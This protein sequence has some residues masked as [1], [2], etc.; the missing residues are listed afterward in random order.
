MVT[1]KKRR[2][3]ARSCLESSVWRG[4]DQNESEWKVV[5]RVVVKCRIDELTYE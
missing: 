2:K 4:R 3:N 1:I 5:G